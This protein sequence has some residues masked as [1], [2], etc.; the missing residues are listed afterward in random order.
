MPTSP[1]GPA[2]PGFTLIELLVVIAIIA[3]LI[4]LLLPAV[5]K[6]REAAARMSCTNNCKQLGLALHNYHDTNN[7]FPPAA[8]SQ[9]F[10]PGWANLHG[11]GM[12]LLPFVEQQNVANLYRWDRNWNAPENQPAVAP[13]L[14]V[15]MCPSAPGDRM[16]AA[17]P[18]TNPAGPWTAS[19]TD[20]TPLTRIAQGAING[21]FVSPSPGNINGMMQTNLRLRFADV[22]DGTSNTIALGEDAGRPGLYRMGR[23][24]NAHR[25]NTAASW[26]DRNNLIAPTGAKADGSSRLGPCAMNCTNDNELYSFHSGGVVAVFGDGSVHFIRSTIT[27]TDLSRLITRAGGEVLTGNEY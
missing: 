20:Y 19:V 13:K 2:R 14:K 4:G 11:W 16:D 12:F 1:R 26:A 27:M 7:H 18:S 25:A 23:Q 24:I 17:P 8:T 10:N 3:I 9:P 22:T 6:V 21:G 15:M 5:Q